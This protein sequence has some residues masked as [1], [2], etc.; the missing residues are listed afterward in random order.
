MKS[1]EEIVRALREHLDAHHPEVVT[2]YLHGSLAR[3]EAAPRDVDVAVL[4]REDPPRTLAG[5]RV[6]LRDELT[7]LLGADVDLAILNRASADFVHRVLVDRTMI[8]DRDPSA[9]IRFEVRKRNEYF[10][11][12][13]HLRRY[14]R[15]REERREKEGEERE[16]GKEREGADADDRHGRQNSAPAPS[17]GSL[18]NSPVPHPGIG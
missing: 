16:E 2:A 3:G 6:D 15:S 14:R 1:R 11:L 9:R 18:P 8:L 5:L 17:H 7:E 4:L 12:L 13:P 10:D